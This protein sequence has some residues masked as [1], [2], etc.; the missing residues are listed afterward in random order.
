MLS[1]CQIQRVL[2]LIN[3]LHYLFH[4]ISG[5]P[6]NIYV[7]NGWQP[8]NNM[9]IIISIV[10]IKFGCRRGKFLL[11]CSLS[12]KSCDLYQTKLMLWS[13]W[14][15]SNIVIKFALTAFLYLDPRCLNPTVNLVLKSIWHA[16]LNTEGKI[17]LVLGR[18][19]VY[20]EL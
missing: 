9:I 10:L 2:R 1:D 4:R 18:E 12:G 14:Q 17:R 15:I 19:L 11:L 16:S 13:F 20:D 6:A 7:V 8:E 5:F 3:F